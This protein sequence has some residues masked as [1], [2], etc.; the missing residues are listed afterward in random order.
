MWDLIPRPGIEPLSPVLAGGFLTTGP[1]GKSPH[2]HF[3][4]TALAIVWS[5]EQ[6]WRRRPGSCRES[7]RRTLQYLRND[8]EVAWRERYLGDESVDSVMDWT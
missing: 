2:L 6:V 7:V 8:G 3:E 5:V 1:P 4:N